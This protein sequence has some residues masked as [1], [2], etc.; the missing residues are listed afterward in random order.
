MLVGVFRA[1]F[2]RVQLRVEGQAVEFIVDTGFRGEITL[3]ARLA[4]RLDAPVVGT[5][6]V[7][8]ADGT[9][10]IA[11]VHLLSVE[12]E[13]ELRLVETLALEGNPLLGT[14]LL[15]GYHVH[16]EISEGGEVFVE[17]L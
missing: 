1:G 7:Q 3:P 5:R 9:S 10:R 15:E 11:P 4:T 12:W 14:E 16:A 13:S 8:L 17:A 2:P 6:V